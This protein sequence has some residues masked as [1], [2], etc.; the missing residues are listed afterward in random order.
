M[1]A[2]RKMR[3]SYNNGTRNNSNKQL[4]KYKQ[5]MNIVQYTIIQFI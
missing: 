1:I 2:L 5:I 4:H 3:C